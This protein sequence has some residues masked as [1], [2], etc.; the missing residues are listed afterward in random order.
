MGTDTTEIPIPLVEPAK[1]TTASTISTVSTTTADPGTPPP[2]AP[3]GGSADTTQSDNKARFWLALAVIV[4]Y[5]TLVGYLIY[6]NAPM[7]DSQFILGAES[8][9]VSLVLGYFFGSSSGSTAKS[10]QLQGK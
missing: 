3:P 1:A 2:P 6:R 7:Q 9:F 10:A 5:V 4:Q 8:S